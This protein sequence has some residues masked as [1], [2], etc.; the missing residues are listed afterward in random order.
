LGRSQPL[1]GSS[2]PAKGS[3][4]PESST[5]ANAIV[6][7]TEPASH[8]P[9]DCPSDGPSHMAGPRSVVELLNVIDPSPIRRRTAAET[10]TRSIWWSVHNLI[11]RSIRRMPSR[12]RRG[13]GAL[14]AWSEYLV[15]TG[16]GGWRRRRREW[17]RLIRER[18]PTCDR[19]GRPVPLHVHVS[20]LDGGRDTDRR[21]PIAERGLSAG[22]R[23]YSASVLR[24][25]L[26]FWIRS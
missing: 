9:N 22:S 19:R 25:L 15:D 3:I 21:T 16:H 26:I 5:G 12:P 6:C 18:L 1:A 2:R 11:R 13:R 7:P 14:W 23:R 10:R 20:R 17:I 4:P 8:P 24:S